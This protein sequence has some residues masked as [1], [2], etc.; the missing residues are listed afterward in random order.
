MSK[1][2]HFA[3]LA[4]SLGALPLSGYSE[5]LKSPW[6]KKPVA[7]KDKSY[8]CP[9]LAS[10]PKDISAF[11]FYSDEQHSKIDSAK[12]EA[13]NAVQDQFRGTEGEAIKAAENFRS[14]GSRA[15][16]ECVL[17]ILDQQADG[18][19][20]TGKMASNQ[21]YYV[22]NWTLGSLAVT[23]LKVRAAEPGT[24]ADR[25]KAIAWMSEVAGDTRSYFTERHQKDT[26]DGTNNHYYWAGF[27]VMS[28]GIAA[29]D[30]ALYDWGIVT[31]K[32]AMSRILPDGTL[33]LEM[34]RGQRALH[35]H[36]FALAP[37]TEMAEMAFANNTELYNAN[38]GALHRLVKRTAAGLGDNT[39]FT[40]KAGT[41]QDTPEKGGLKSEDVIWLTPYLKHF[42]DP[43]LNRLLNSVTLKPFGYLGGFPPS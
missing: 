29:N 8:S 40:A 20:M 13:Y 30:S 2:I 14:T 15:A 37:L 7:I 3:L 36:V 31:Y 32:E 1:L 5:P 24:P 9:K 41:K 19:A 4:A 16:A 21:S 17:T 10:L 35:Y 27:A 6:D 18:N 25:A 38:G 39:Y 22:Q 23:W 43:A 34:D 12:Y 26:K 28:A 33:P 42:P 11:S